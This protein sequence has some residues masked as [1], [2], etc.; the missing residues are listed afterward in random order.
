MQGPGLEACTWTRQR[1]LGT[2]LRVQLTTEQIPDLTLVAVETRAK[3]GCRARLTPLCFSKDF[4][5]RGA[6]PQGQK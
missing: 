5:V 6:S 2:C 1:L 4:C 3:L